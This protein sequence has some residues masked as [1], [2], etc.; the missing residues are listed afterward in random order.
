MEPLLARPRSSA[1]SA[2]ST[3]ALLRSRVNQLTYAPSICSPPSETSPSSHSSLHLASPA[4]EAAPLGLHGG[5]PAPPPPLGPLA[6]LPI[7]T[8]ILAAAAFAALALQCEPAIA[9]TLSGA[10][11]VVDG[12][13][14]EF[15]SE[16]VRLFGVDAPESKQSCKDRGGKDFPCGV[17]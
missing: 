9:D 16:R 1:T 7:T 2:I 11:R 17:S 12:D 3:S 8:A 6:A 5:P 13:T 10:P 14:L 4:R 15:G